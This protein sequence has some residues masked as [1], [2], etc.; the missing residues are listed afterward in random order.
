M[1]VLIY[2]HHYPAPEE[3]GLVKDTKVVH[4]FAKMLMEKGHRVQV[5]YLTYWPVK[6]IALSH[7]RALLPVYSDYTYEGVPVHLIQYQ[8]L[9]PRRVYPESFQA[10]LINAHLKEM[11]ANRHFAA[12]QVFVH[13]PIMFTGLTEIFR[14]CP[15]VL[16]DFHNMDVTFLKERDPKG[17]MLSF[18]RRIPT[19][20]YRN[21]GVRSY[22]AD[23][24]SGAPVPVYTGID[25]ALL[26]SPDFIE[27]KKRR[28]PRPLRLLYAGQLI[29]LKNVDS[30]IRAFRQLSFDAEL[31]IIGDGSERKALEQL[32]AG[33]G[34]ISFTGW[35]PRE[36]VLEHMRS[37]DVFAMISS[38]ETYGLVYLEAI[39]QGCIAIA[40]RG[41]GFD[42][43]IEDG[44]NGFLCAPGDEK[45]LAQIL[46]NLAAM[47]AQEKNALID[48][49]YALAVS[50]TED[51]T[52]DGFLA[53]NAHITR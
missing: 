28:N 17:R 30:L 53:A 48:S 11:K 16:G 27:Q 49:G 29:P 26:S 34:R 40:S 14:D 35:L 10:K 15:N 38:P 8:M 22:L 24:L 45:E 2:T 44:K 32:A 46:E 42:G 21:K 37:A 52:T 50:M 51:K 41:E 12:D 1:N 25:A 4:Y 36:Q 9:T 23:T 5:V 47:S 33:K 39:A 3:L 19:W 7:L 18:I 20:G 6:E 31:T 13:F 43:L